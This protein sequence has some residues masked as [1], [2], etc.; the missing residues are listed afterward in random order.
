[1]DA[2]FRGTHDRAVAPTRTSP[3]G[4]LHPGPCGQEPIPA[5]IS[6]SAGPC[7]NPCPD[8]PPSSQ[9]FSCAGWRSMMKLLSGLF[10]YWQTRDSR[11]AEHP[12][13][14]ESGRRCNRGS[15]L[16][17]SGL[18]V[19]SPEV[20]S[21]SGPR[22]IVCDFEPSPLISRNAVDEPIAMISPDRQLVCV[23]RLSPAGAPKKNTSCLVGSNVI[24]DG[25]RKQL[26]LA[27][28][29]RRRRTDRQPASSHRRNA[30]SP[31]CALQITRHNR[32]LSIFAAFRKKSVEHR[33]ASYARRKKPALGLVNSP[34]HALPG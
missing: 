33:L 11:A 31:T 21:N 12:S 14:Q 1:M 8:P 32:R 26:S 22:R 27:T 5:T 18:T 29:R 15:I 16:R 6:P 25:F 19:L 34:M 4:T 9:T 20:G 30:G 3:G 10:S 24:A 13:K 28:D 2:S 17:P 23:K 7:L